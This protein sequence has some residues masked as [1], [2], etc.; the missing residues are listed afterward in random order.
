MKNVRSASSLFQM[1]GCLIIAAAL[2]AWQTDKT[3]TA[4]HKTFGTTDQD[5][6]IPKSADI[7]QIN[8]QLNLDSAMQ[9]VNLAMSKIDYAKMN[10]DVQKAIAQ[11][12]YNKINKEINAAMKNIDW[13]QMKMDI[14]KSLDSAKMA[15]D[16]INWD[17]MKAD[18]SKAQIEAK[19][20]MAAQ[21]I[22]MDSIQIQV[23]KSLKEAQRNLQSVKIEMAN[24]KGLKTALEKDGLLQEGKPHS[25]ELRDGI[26]YLNKVK[27]SKAITDKYSKYYSGKKNF[28]LKDDGGIDL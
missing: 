21:K 5:T 19:R 24:D 28:I 14:S 22:N 11:V 20:A 15:I 23:Q 6:T 16:K 25:I 17:E 3:K 13:S 18:V 26:L 10:A 1:A 27:Q 2:I 12:D 7:D 4:Q 9:Q 8:L